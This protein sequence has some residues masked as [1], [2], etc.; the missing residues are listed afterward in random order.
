MKLLN[1][2]FSVL[3]LCY[4]LGIVTGY[5]LQLSLAPII[6]VFGVTFSLFLFFKQKANKRFLQKSDFTLV[7]FLI[8]F[9][10]GGI[11]MQIHL[12]KN[13]QTHY[14]HQTNY[15]KEHL[16][17]V[18][19]THALK[20]SAN[21]NRYEGVLLQMDSSKVR[22]KVLINIK[23]N[24]SK[25]LPTGTEFATNTTLI[26]IN[27]P[28][29]PGQFNYEDYL[30]K[31][32]IY[33]QLYINQEELVSLKTTPSLLVLTQEYRE[34]IRRN[35]EKYA[36]DAKE[37]AIMNA[38]LLGYRNDISKEMYAN[39]AAAGVIHILAIS[40]LHVGILLLFLNYMFSPLA[41][42]KNGTVYKSIIVILLLWLFALLTGFSP[43]VVR[44]VTMFS[45]FAYAL[46]R[47]KLTSTFNVLFTSMFFL[48]LFKPLLIFDVGFQLSYSAVLAIIWI[49][50]IIYKKWVPRYW[51]TKYLWSILCVTFSAQLGLLPLSLYYFHQFPSLFFL[52]NLVILPFLGLI[53]GSGVLIIILS[54][55]HLLPNFLV[56]F[57][58]NILKLLHQFVSWIAQQEAFVF[59]GLFFDIKML[60]ASYVLIIGLVFLLQKT[61]K[62]NIVIS[63]VGFLCLFGLIIWNNIAIK[64]QDSLIVFHQNRETLIAKHK[65]EK[66]IIYGDLL[67]KPETSYPIKNY[68]IQHP[69]KTIQKEMLPVSLSTHKERIIILDSLQDPIPIPK[70]QIILLVNSPKI[71]LERIIKLYEPK[72]I[73]SDGS[74]YISLKKRWKQTCKKEKLP[75]H[76]TYEKGAYIL[77]FTE[78]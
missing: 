13:F 59:K 2:K 78:Y 28:L 33:H 60:I 20:S 57:Y 35:L 16:W 18:K 37:L 5:Y 75:F 6:I 71:N 7:S 72:M 31:R 8:F 11:V 66:L 43:S 53:L 41:S 14:T 74:N 62:K 38:L 22:G 77:D 12:E 65:G 39:F 58:A 9:L 51:I 76:D 27:K 44:S 17:F 24:N 36:F 42:V 40:G 19:V 30:A 67:K 54:M 52:S 61:S 26:S 56:T 25:T 63:T 73:I 15:Q 32:Q 55:T 21:Y 10:L 1:Y 48:L 49:Q 69:A 50:P 47:K 68:Q 3:V 34:T 4:I 45:F 23:I 46:N 64:K 29:N 70:R